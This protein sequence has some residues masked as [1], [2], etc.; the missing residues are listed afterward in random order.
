MELSMLIP[1]LFVAALVLAAPSTP[2]SNAQCPTCPMK[3]TEKSPAV[4]VRGRL[5]RV[6][7]MDCGKDLQKNADKYLEKDGRPKNAKAK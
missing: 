6:C 7:C 3:V 1:G 2:A 4:D 5:Y